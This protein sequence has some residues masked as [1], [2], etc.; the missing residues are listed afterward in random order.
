MRTL[1]RR[2]FVVFVAMSLAACLDLT[3]SVIEKATDDAAPGTTLECLQCLSAPNVPGPGCGDQLVACQMVPICSR[4]ME[5]TFRQGCYGLQI[6]ELPICFRA[7]ADL[8]GFRS[9]D[10]PETKPALEWYQ[11]STTHCRDVCLGGDAGQGPD[12]GSA[13]SSVDAGG[14]DAEATEA[15]GDASGGAC[16]NPSDQMAE[17]NATFATAPRDCGLMCFGV[18]NPNCAAQCMQ[19]KGLSGACAKCWGDSINCG[20]KNCLGQCLDSES[21]ACRQCSA[22]YCDP[23]FHACAGM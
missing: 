17:A 13:D 2:W 8:V 3:P 21:M 7:C 10:S 14:S 5:C 4:G 22:Q 12:G 9:T 18:T 23:A 19:D 20:I 16:T 6:D 15:S 11:C 1:A